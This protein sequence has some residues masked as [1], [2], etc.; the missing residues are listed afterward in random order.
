MYPINNTTIG[1]EQASLGYFS[2][3]FVNGVEITGGGGFAFGTV[4]VSGQSDI[5]AETSSDT[6]TIVAG[7]NITLTTN[8]VTD[9][10]TIDATGGGITLG[11]PVNASGTSV[12]FTG[13]PAGTKRITV[14]LSGISTNGTSAPI[15]QLG[16]A[17]GFEAVGYSGAVVNLNNSASIGGSN[18]STGFDLVAGGTA[19]T[20]IQHG[21]LTL[22]LVSAST[23]L[24]CAS[25][26]LGRS[27]GPNTMIV[28]G[29]KSLTG[30]LTQIRLTTI[31]GA[32]TFDA[33]VINIQ[34]E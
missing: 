22:T 21:I 4:A 13:I 7:T 16:D 33:G 34:Y 27:D 5:V 10:L 8:A 32:D 20:L 12:N 15:I 9:T 11:T 14:M 1:I 17:G 18:I 6:L 3:L 23:N 25:G 26:V 30:E 24:W 29:S 28:G 19:A 31:L 2:Q